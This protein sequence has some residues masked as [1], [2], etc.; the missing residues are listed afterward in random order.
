MSG[1]PTFCLSL[2]VSSCITRRLVVP[3]SVVSSRLTMR[4]I[5]MVSAVTDSGHGCPSCGFAEELQNF[6]LNAA[7]KTSGN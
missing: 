3:P 4:V 1:A 6:M 7:V 5:P 2:V